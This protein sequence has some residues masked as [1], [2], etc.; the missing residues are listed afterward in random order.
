MENKAN[1]TLPD[2]PYMRTYEHKEMRFRSSTFRW[3]EKTYLMGIIN[4]TPDS[5]SGDGIYK[6]VEEVVTFARALVEAG[7]SIAPSPAEIGV[8]VQKVLS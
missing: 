6:N 2:W 8:T 5:F 7:V 4:V 1:K 3:G